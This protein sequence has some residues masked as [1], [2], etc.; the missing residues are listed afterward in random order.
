M[1]RTLSDANAG[2]NFRG[3]APVHSGGTGQD[4]ASAAL[5]ALNGVAA[6]EYNQPNGVAQLN[7]AGYLPYEILP[8]NVSSSLGLAGPTVL[9]VGTQGV[10][11]IT[12]YD[13]HVDYTVTAATGFV[14]RS[15]DRIYYTAPSTPG[16]HGFTINNKVI[17]VPVDDRY[18][19]QPS[20]TSPVNDTTN[21]G[22]GLIVTG[23]E[24]VVQ[25]GFPST[26]LTA[27]DKA[28]GDIFGV[29]VA[30]AGDG[31][32]LAVGAHVKDV[33]GVVDAGQVYIYTWTGSAWVPE[34]TLSA[35]DKAFNNAF[36]IAVALDSTG[37]RL[38]VGAHQKTIGGIS[39][40][41]Q[42]Y[43]YTRS[44][45]VWTLESTLSAADK[46]I[47]DNFG[48]GVA[49][50][51]TG[52]RLA[53][54]AYRKT[55]DGIVAAGQ[56]YVYTRSGSVWSQEATLSA[57][58]KAANDFF[59]R[60]VSLN[61]DGSKLASGATRKTVGGLSQA[62]QVY[63][64]T[65]SGTTWTQDSILT[66]SDK[67]AN[68]WFG[69]SVAL[70]SSGSK[71]FIGNVNK[72]NGNITDSG[73]VY[74]FNQ[75]GTQWIQEYQLTSD[76]KAMG[77]GFGLSVAIDATE[78]K[79]VVGAGGKDVAGLTDTGQ[80]YIYDASYH[81]STDWELSTDIGFVTIAQQSLADTVN[82]RS[83]H[84]DVLSLNT[85]YYIR[86]RYNGT[87]YG[88]SE[89]STPIHFKTR[90]AWLPVNEI[91]IITA[92]DKAANDL[93]GTSVAIAGDG[94]RMAIGT[95]DKTVG[96]ISAAGQ[97]Y[98]YTWSGSTWVQESTLS[99]ADKATGDYFGSTVTLDTTGSRLVVGAHNKTV[100]GFTGAGQVYTYTR[101]GSVWTQESTLVLADAA[102]GD[103]FGVTA[104][105]AADSSRL[106]VGAYGKIVG[107]VSGAGQVYTYT[108]SGATW[109]LETTLSA[110]DKAAGDGFGITVSVDATATRLAVGARSR[111]NGALTDSGKVYF[112]TRTGTT[113]TEESTLM[114]PDAAAGDWFGWGL[115]LS[116]DGTLL[117][118][119][120]AFRTVDGLAAA[121][122]MQLYVLTGG[123]WSLEATLSA[124][125]KAATDFF[126]MNMAFT[127]DRSKMAV[128][129]FSRNSDGLTNSGAVYLFE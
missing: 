88:T 3:V 121:G 102:G 97:V 23:S 87:L 59:G 60:S 44:G 31:T 49:M 75:V 79:L 19:A 69:T 11:T 96:G 33:G 81:A 58:D 17:P 85:D 78:A 128:C 129:A 55:V 27:A 43:V 99:A 112:Y 2:Q 5:A 62:G 39:G 118:V 124:S 61:A 41:G 82:R 24:F 115:A 32:R 51:S 9:Y 123:T 20:I 84:V 109:V 50:D 93:F 101:A 8:A 21:M 14:S 120:R 16:T 108:R 35:A 54:G 91:S 22:S 4:T 13:S 117:A 15:G 10:W 48:V 95:R 7:P 6:A 63:V 105:I 92:S 70:N 42:V 30:L 125:D 126:G 94:S 36:G 67:A 26:I 29:S 25:G 18:V 86:C 46:A 12:N 104:S 38:V 74:I 127:A 34:T 90:A 57:S 1:S 28:A 71:L 119:G 113:W 76:D 122:Q 107:G 98:I 64:F 73:K 100:A 72:D 114:A 56:V 66:A 37:S 40:A 80:I 110:A 106:V 45:S 103:S 83:W 52:S 65:R 116:S 111:E 53:V 77:D 47:D 89:W 68:D